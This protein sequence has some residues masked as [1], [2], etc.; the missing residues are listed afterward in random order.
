MSFREIK[1]QVR[2]IQIIQDYIRQSRVAGG[3]LFLGPEAIGK[4]LAAY[5]FAKALNCQRDTVDSCDSCPSCLKIDKHQHPDVRSIGEGS[6]SDTENPDTQD[7]KIDQIRQ[8]QRE[9]NLKAYE[10]RKK[11]FIID[12]AHRLTPE[13][14]NAL[15][16]VLEEPPADSVIILI[17]SQPKLLFKTI[18]SRCQVVKFYPINRIWLKELLKKDYGLSEEAAHFLAYFSE[19]RIGRAIRLKDTETL[20]QKNLVIDNFTLQDGSY[21][22]EMAKQNREQL[23]N[24][25]N[26]LASWFRDIYIMKAGLAHSE[27]INI[28]RKQQLLRVMNRYSFTDLDE[29]LNLISDALFYIEQNINL[30]LL[31]SNLIENINFNCG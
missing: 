14:S 13:A 4:R 11:V 8:L 22:Q 5:T 23:R 3:Y 7:I 12:N 19:G 18:V 21:I 29:I 20:K 26:I 24:Q 15:L 27:I 28:D 6:I 30:R 2:P 1:G 31:L 10:A 25:L 9:I 16:K 17:S